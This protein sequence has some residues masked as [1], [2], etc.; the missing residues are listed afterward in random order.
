MIVVGLK[1]TMNKKYKRNQK[2]FEKMSVSSTF[3]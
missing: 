2:T 3:K 1:Y